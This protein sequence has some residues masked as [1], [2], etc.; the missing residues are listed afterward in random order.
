LLLSGHVVVDD[1]SAFRIGSELVDTGIFILLLV[2]FCM[3]SCFK[4]FISSVSLLW[5]NNS[6]FLISL[7]LLLLVVVVVSAVSKKKEK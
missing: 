1:V 7:L 2:L 4:L 6:I 3:V 5:F